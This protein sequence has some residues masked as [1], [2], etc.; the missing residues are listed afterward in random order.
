MFVGVSVVV[1]FGSD[2]RGQARPN[3]AL[4]NWG[5]PIDP[6]R[7]CWTRLVGETLAIDVPGSTHDLRG[8]G[9][10][11]AP[12]V[13]RSIDGDFIAQVKVSGNLRHTGKRT[14]GLSVA[15]HGAG[16]LIWQNA[17]NYVRLER[18]GLVR[19]DGQT[20]HF[21]NFELH[22]DGQ[23]VVKALE[24]PD[25][26]TYLRLERRG[27]RVFGLVTGDGYKWSS[28][29][30]IAARLP[31]DVKLGVVAISTSTEPL[32]VVFSDLEVLKREANEPR[33]TVPAAGR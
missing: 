19:E 14:S 20:V 5:Q 25:Q 15:Y 32:K 24:I 10:V 23:V 22:R 29:E 7:D 17:R 16:L 27:N 8:D 13:V 26:D 12:R 9:E 30:P 21:A 31:R 18:S 28:L 33:K 2:A 6:S 3:S 4:A 11:N 1:C